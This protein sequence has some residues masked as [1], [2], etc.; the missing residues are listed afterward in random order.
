[1]IIIDEGFKSAVRLKYIL[2]MMHK[3]TQAAKLL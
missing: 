2:D 3:K 1:M